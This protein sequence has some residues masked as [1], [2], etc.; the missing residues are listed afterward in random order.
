MGKRD[1]RF[2]NTASKDG[3][4]SFHLKREL[5]ERLTEYCRMNNLNKSK[6]IEKIIAE[7]LIADEKAWLQTLTKEELVQIIMNNGKGSAITDA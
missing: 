6:Y 4:Y 3:C 1:Y 5:N 2:K 7:R